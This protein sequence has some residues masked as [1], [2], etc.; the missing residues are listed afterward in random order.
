LKRPW[1]REAFRRE[2]ELVNA[3]LDELIQKSK[4]SKRVG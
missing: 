1:E 2:S 3:L 4:K